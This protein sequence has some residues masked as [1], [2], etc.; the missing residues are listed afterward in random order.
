ML[1]KLQTVEQTV[2]QGVDVGGTERVERQTDSV[3]N[4]IRPPRRDLRELWPRRADDEQRN[5]RGQRRDMLEQVEQSRLGPM[6]VLDHHDEWPAG[7]RGRL[8]QAAHRPCNL[9]GL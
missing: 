4:L 7:Q 6:D 5:V 2:E 1:R 9:G 8:E 3:R